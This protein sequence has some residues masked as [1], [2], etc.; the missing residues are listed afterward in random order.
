MYIYKYTVIINLTILCDAMKEIVIRQYQDI[1]NQASNYVAGLS[2][3]P[4]GWLRTVRNALGMSGAQLAR[5]LGASRALVGQSER[6]EIAG[7]VTLKTLQTMAEA[8]GCRVVYTIVPETSIDDVIKVR[9]RKRAEQ[10]I[11][12]ADVHMALEDQALDQEQ[13]R[14]EL[15]RLE[16]ELIR[17]MPSNLWDD[18]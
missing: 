3:P 2:M 13:H 5:R 9:A 7:V 11:Q 10:L 8:M 1:V 16:N 4:E 18:D 12:Q 15:R 17:N 14:F 6:N